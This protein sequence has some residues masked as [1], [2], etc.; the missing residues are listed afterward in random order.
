MDVPSSRQLFGYRVHGLQLG[1]SFQLSKLK[2]LSRVPS[3]NSLDAVIRRG[4][5]LQAPEAGDKTTIDTLESS[6]RIRSQFGTVEVS[7][8]RVVLFPA[9]RRSHDELFTIYSVYIAGFL[10]Y[11]RDYLTLHASAVEVDGSTIAFIGHKGMGK[12]STASYFYGQGHRILSDDMIACR[13]TTGTSGLQVAPGFPWM[14]LNADALRFSLNQN[15]A[16]LDRPVPTSDKRMV[17]VNGQQPESARPLTHIYMLGYHEKDDVRI[18][19]TKQKQAC[20]HL[21]ANSYAR[22]FLRPESSGPRHLSQCVALSKEIYISALLRP[23]EDIG[24]LASVY[25]LVCRDVHSR[26]AGDSQFGKSAF[27]LKT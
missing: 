8:H 20:L 3:A 13:P 4:E 19:S 18:E 25:D 1:A 11:Y 27:S 15:G 14:K 22:R 9:P 6:I 26:N 5:S 2:P 17:S 10:L 23:R 21:L 24:A 7:P 16:N 12:S